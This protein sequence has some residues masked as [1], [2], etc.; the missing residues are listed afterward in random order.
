MYGYSIS[1]S[2]TVSILTAQVPATPQAPVTTWNPDDVIISWVAPDYG[3]S[4]IS[5]YRISIK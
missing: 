5:G 4:P 2:N 1:F 3:G